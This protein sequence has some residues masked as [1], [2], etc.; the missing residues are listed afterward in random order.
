MFWVWMSCLFEGVKF[1][2]LSKHQKLTSLGTCFEVAPDVHINET[3]TSS[4]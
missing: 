1:Y 4:Q 3:D 2:S